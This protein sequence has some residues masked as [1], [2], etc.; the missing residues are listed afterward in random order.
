MFRTCLAE[1]SLS[2]ARIASGRVCARLS[3]TRTCR[4]ADGGTLGRIA[5]RAM[6]P[7]QFARICRHSESSPTIQFQGADR[8]AEFQDSMRLTARTFRPTLRT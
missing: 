4:D 1:L 7:T 2:V 8:S 3:A 5:R 6:L